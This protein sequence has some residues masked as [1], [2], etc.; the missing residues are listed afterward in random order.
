ME[1]EDRLQEALDGIINAEMETRLALNGKMRFPA[2]RLRQVSDALREVAD[3]VERA[4]HLLPTKTGK[5][6]P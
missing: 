4:S 1:F 6:R 3:N 5:A 2:I